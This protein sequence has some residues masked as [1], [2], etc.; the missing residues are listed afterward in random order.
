MDLLVTG[1][2]HKRTPLEIRERVYFDESDLRT[3]VLE[4]K[5][6]KEIEEAVLVSTCN[7]MEVYARAADFEQAV[8]SIQEFIGQF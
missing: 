2:S 5:A 7:R 8:S 3:P 6:R 4:L 1:I